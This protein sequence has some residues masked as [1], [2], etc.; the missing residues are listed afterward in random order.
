MRRLSFFKGVFHFQFVHMIYSCCDI[1]VP[2]GGR[3]ER[4]CAHL[5]H[6]AIPGQ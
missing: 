3:E 6:L 5:R 4:S 2:P 1:V